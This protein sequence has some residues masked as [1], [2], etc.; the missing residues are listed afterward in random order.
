MLKPA[1][2]IFQGSKLLDASNLTIIR[3]F[4]QR[5]RRSFAELARKTGLWLP[6]I[7]ERVKRLED[8]GIIPGYRAEVDPSAFGY[9][10][11]AIVSLRSNPGRYA[12]FQ[13]TAERMPEILE[14]HHVTG[15]ESFF[16][17]LIARSIPHLEELIGKLS[18]FGSTS[19]SIVLSSP[20]LRT[21][22]A[23]PEENAARKPKRLL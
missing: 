14:C 1:Q 16:L 6:A 10:L 13:A 19:T 20:I 23:P 15:S 22:V 8:A 11:T 3:E 4:Q 17:K 21:T 9:E 18:A 7:S 12:R 2:P 5:G